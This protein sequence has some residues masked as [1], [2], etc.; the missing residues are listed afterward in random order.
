MRTRTVIRLPKLDLQLVLNVE[1]LLTP[2]I[3]PFIPFPP[4]MPS[5]Y[6]RQISELITLR[7][8]TNSMQSLFRTISQSIT[9]NSVLF[10]DITSAPVR[11]FVSLISTVIKINSSPL[12]VHALIVQPP[13]KG[14]YWWIYILGFLMG[15]AVL[16]I[17]KDRKDEEEYSVPVEPP[18][19]PME[20]PEIPKEPAP[21]RS[22]QAHQQPP[23]QREP[24]SEKTVL[25]KKVQTPKTPTPDKSKQKMIPR[26]LRYFRLGK[27]TVSAPYDPDELDEPDQP[28]EEPPEQS[29]ESVV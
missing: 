21:V 4:I 29:S 9:L 27:T 12:I 20:P 18:Q 7:A 3:P 28:P 6:I 25:S 24:S 17:Y 14:N 16:V 10:I 1:Q 15:L 13:G 26:L 19:P 5:T 23:T 22:T 2:Y 8:P 11:L